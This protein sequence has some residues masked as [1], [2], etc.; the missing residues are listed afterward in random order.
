MQ[1]KNTVNKQVLRTR[2]WIFN[3]LLTL[4]ETMPYEDIKI[5]NITDKADVAR[6][7]F[8]R[9]Y[10][11]KDDIIVNYLDDRF[12]EFKA[13]A[14]EAQNRSTAATFILSFELF[15]EHREALIK[16]K[17][18]G[19]DYLLF[20]QLLSYNKYFLN[21][22]SEK[23]QNNSNLHNEYFVKFQ[24]G[25]LATIVLEW[26]KRD[27]SMTPEEIGGIVYEIVRLFKDQDGYLPDILSKKES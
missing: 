15:M 25:G 7:T 14:K 5:S 17:N 20:N 18:A 21:H 9:N 4:L 10:K 26:I 2:E 11:S 16:I 23:E 3:A 19:L 13:K 24:V 22:V 6:Q 8:Y 1:Q 27:M 12:N